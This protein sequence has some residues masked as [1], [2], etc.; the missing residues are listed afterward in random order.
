V[1]VAAAHALQHI[2]RVAIID[3]DIHHG[4]GTQEI[5]YDSGRVLYCS[6][7]QAHSYPGTGSPEETGTGEGEGNTINIPVPAG[8]TIEIYRGAF[9]STII[10]AVRAYDPDL[11]LVSAGQDI[12]ADDTL[13]RMEILP[14]DFTVLTRLVLQTTDNP[15]ALVLEGG[16]GPSHGEAIAAIFRALREG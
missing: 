6:I 14:E 3:W 16:Y 13:G 1:A 10:P 9:E 2:D 11:V 5:F 8:S 7:H 12:L 15:L 4:N